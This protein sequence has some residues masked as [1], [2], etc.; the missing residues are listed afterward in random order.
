MNPL[1]RLR[2]TVAPT[3][4]GGCG[5]DA[6][7]ADDFHH[8]VRV[9]LTGTRHAY[10]GSYRGTT[11][12]LAQTLAQGW[13]YTGQDYAAWGRARGEPADALPPHAF[14]HCLENHDQVGNRA[15]GERLEHL[16][17]PAAF[18]AAGPPSTISTSC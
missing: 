18:R 12:D 1:D 11:V 6:V 9:A 15:R 8:Q 2:Q 17:T 7:W 14:V 13:F 3:G 16:T 5:I 10:F 4:E